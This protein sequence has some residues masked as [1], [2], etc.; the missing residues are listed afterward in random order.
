MLIKLTPGVN[1]I[2]SKAEQGEHSLSL[3]VSQ[4]KLIVP[5]VTSTL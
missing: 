3:S 5:N 4:T 2:K 1:F